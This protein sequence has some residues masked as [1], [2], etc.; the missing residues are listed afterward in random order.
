MEKKLIKQ[1]ETSGSSIL[2]NVKIDTGHTS[3]LQ[4]LDAYELTEYLEN[5]YNRAYQ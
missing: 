2:G 1:N 4:Y 5:Q 3:V